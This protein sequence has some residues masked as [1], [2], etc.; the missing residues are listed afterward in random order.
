MIYIL[1]SLLPLICNFAIFWY[2]NKAKFGHHAENSNFL[3]SLQFNITFYTEKHIWNQKKTLVNCTLLVTMIMTSP[4]IL[5]YY[6]CTWYINFKI[7]QSPQTFLPFCRI[8]A[9]LCYNQS[10]E[11]TLHVFKQGESHWLVYNIALQI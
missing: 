3:A 2:L 7:M 5:P 4:N 8:Y 10:F 6:Y 11:L 9:S 1:N